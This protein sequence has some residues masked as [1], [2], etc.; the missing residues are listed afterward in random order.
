M[1]FKSYERGPG[2]LSSPTRASTGLPILPSRPPNP[3][4]TTTLKSSSLPRH[5]SIKHPNRPAHHRLHSA[6]EPD[7]HAC[8]TGNRGHGLCALANLCHDFVRFAVI[9]LHHLTTL[10]PSPRCSA[11]HLTSRN[12]Y[13]DSPLTPLTTKGELSPLLHCPASYIV[14]RPEMRYARTS[15]D[16]S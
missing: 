8:Q 9:Q 5:C 11:I 1:E 12:P 10:P 3:S 15:H 6:A 16:V 14:R 4:S 13:R 2:K 7:Y